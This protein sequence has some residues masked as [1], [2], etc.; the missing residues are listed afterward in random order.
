MNFV[1]RIGGRGL[2]LAGGD[3]L[4]RWRRV[5][6]R[7]DEANAFTRDGTDQLLLFAAVADCLADGIDAAGERRLRHDSSAPDAR[8]EI[9][10][11]HYV[12]A[13]PDQIDQ[14]VEYLRLHGNQR[15]AAFKLAPAD[16]KYMI[17]E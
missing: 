6:D 4:A 9:V 2:R 3:D 12:V 5:T 15:G 7:A 16:V 8:D 13:V 14:Q 1:L 17:S 11:A 10:L